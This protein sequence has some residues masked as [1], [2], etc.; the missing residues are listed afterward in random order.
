VPLAHIGIGHTRSR[1]GD[2]KYYYHYLVSAMCDHDLDFTN[3]YQ[4]PRYPWE[5][6]NA[7][8]YGSGVVVSKITG[9]PT[10]LFPGG[11][12]LLW[13][14]FYMVTTLAATVIG[15]ILGHGREFSPWG[16]LFQYSV[17]YS[18]VV[19]ALG[20][21]LLICRLQAKDH[22]HRAAV[23]TIVIILFGTNLL[24]Y[25]VIEPSYGLRTS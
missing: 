20:A 24:H 4:R 11:V 25:T 23:T 9:R 12:A 14:P 3:D 21:M 8:Q 18:G 7:D 2:G 16:R 1:E 10:N 5:K 17:M 19:F 13:S 6:T 15:S 22:G